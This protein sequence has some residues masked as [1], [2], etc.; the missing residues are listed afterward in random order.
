MLTRGYTFFPSPPKMPASTH[1][2]QECQHARGVLS[3]AEVGARRT[4][5]GATGSPQSLCHS[6][7]RRRRKYLE[8]THTLISTAS[9]AGVVPWLPPTHSF[10]CLPTCLSVLSVC[11][12]CLSC[13]SVRLCCFF[14]SSV[15]LCSDGGLGRASGEGRVARR[16][17]RGGTGRV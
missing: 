1:S 17:L 12:V 10:F 5:K 6:Q 11:P 15:W 14:C 2:K 9:A 8:S 13:L 16:C 3:A 4:P 7:A